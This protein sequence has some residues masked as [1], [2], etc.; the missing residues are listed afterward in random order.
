MTARDSRR[1]RFT[2][3]TFYS[4]F[5]PVSGRLNSELTVVKFKVRLEPHEAPHII[6]THPTHSHT[7]FHSSTPSLHPLTDTYLRFFYQWRQQ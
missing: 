1:A 3:N 4:R 5:T 6:N 2:D 7:F